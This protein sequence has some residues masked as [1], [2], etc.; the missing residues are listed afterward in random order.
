MVYFTGPLLLAFL[1]FYCYS[2]MHVYIPMVW[3]SLE[4]HLIPP[5]YQNLIV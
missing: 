4:T 5:A 3:I 1:M 2:D